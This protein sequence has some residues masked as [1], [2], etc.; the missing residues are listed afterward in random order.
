MRNPITIPAP[1]LIAGRCGRRDRADDGE[2]IDAPIDPQLSAVSRLP[3]PHGVRPRSNDDYVLGLGWERAPAA[4]SGRRTT[5]DSR[6]SRTVYVMNADGGGRYAVHLG[7]PQ[8]VPE[9][10]PHPDDE[11]D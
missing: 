4:R 3:N 8:Y 7:G 11:D 5:L 2:H 9:R 1:A 6:F 10:Q